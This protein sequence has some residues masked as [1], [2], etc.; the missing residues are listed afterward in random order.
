[1]KSARHRRTNAT[2]DGQA[3]GSLVKSGVM[4]AWREVGPVDRF[5]VGRTTPATLES[6]HT[7]DGRGPRIPLYVRRR[8][9]GSFVVFHGRCPHVGAPLTWKPDSGCFTTPCAGSVFGPE[10]QVLI[11]PA[12]RPVDRHAWKV[13]KG[14]LFVGRIARESP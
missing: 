3:P 9:D 5:E 12:P 7:T 6:P 13:E 8:P 2:R 11:G 1:M 14:V 4:V 10:G